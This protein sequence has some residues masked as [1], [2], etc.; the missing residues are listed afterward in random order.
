V[1]TAVWITWEN[2]IRNKS[3]SSRLGAELYVLSNNRT[4]LVRYVVCAAKSF[5][6]IWR[7]R[8]SLVFAQN[9]SIV[10]AYLLILLRCVFRYTLVS[11]A[12]YA[13]VVA[14]DGNRFFQKALDFYNR[15]ADFVI[16]TNDEHGKRVEAIGGNAL[17]CEDPLPDIG[18]YTKA[19][20]EM[21][22][23]V[24]FICSFDVDEPYAETFQAAEAL[25]E[26]GYTFWVSGNFKK[27]G[28]DPVEWP[29]IHFLGY[30]P[31]S[32][33]YSHMAE[34]Q[35][36]VD[37]TTQENC[38]VCGAYEAMVLGRPLVTSNTLALR[39]YFSGGAIFVDHDPGCIADGVRL[40]YEQRE[41]LKLN[42][43]EWRRQAVSE[44]TKKIK[45]IRELLRLI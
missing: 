34:S 6:L 31:E 25:H 15:H 9:P 35:V 29:S 41:T 42:I 20:G 36:V 11:D 13:G 7:R 26:E 12:H 21:V 30:V 5:L 32:V 27:V 24:F 28:I 22:K 18:R 19:D 2:Q 8:P 43:E 37:L 23:K 40:A 14:P 39:K 10:L 33:F 3:L 45:N 44:N 38:L 1:K 17:V 4:R 16:V